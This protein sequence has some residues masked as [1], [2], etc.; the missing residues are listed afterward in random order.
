MSED[1][2]IV[3]QVTDIHFEWTITLTE[4]TFNL[5][6]LKSLNHILMNIESLKNEN[7]PRGISVSQLHKYIQIYFML[8]VVYCIYCT[9]LIWLH[10]CKIQ[11]HI[12]WISSK[13]CLCAA[14][15]SYIINI[16]C[17]LGFC[18]GTADRWFHLES[19][20]FRC[21]DSKVWFRNLLALW[22]RFLDIL[23]LRFISGTLS[24]YDSDC[25]THWLHDSHS[26]CKTYLL[27]ICWL[28]DWDS[29]EFWGLSMALFKFRDWLSMI[30]R[31]FGSLIQI[32]NLLNS[33]ANWQ[34][35]LNWKTYESDS[36]FI[37]YRFK[38]KDRHS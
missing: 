10:I 30:Q 7:N 22:F 12:N 38:F 16:N 23:C 18:M 6:D 26:Y 14:C 29:K 28:T 35:G 36:R 1:K 4:I 2:N 24:R 37:D 19:F 8:I 13:V 34:H 31:L 3:T 32:Q 9:I 21:I 20:M 5:I 15:G 33:E 11:A 17:V 27:R 25:E